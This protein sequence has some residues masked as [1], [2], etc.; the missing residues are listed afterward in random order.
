MTADRILVV[1]SKDAENEAV[2]L[3]GMASA[4]SSFYGG[5]RAAVPQI[6]TGNHWPAWEAY[7]RCGQF[8]HVEIGVSGFSSMCRGNVQRGPRLVRHGLFLC[9]FGGRIGHQQRRPAR[10]TPEG[11]AKSADTGVYAPT[12]PVD[13]LNFPDCVAM[14]FWTDR[15]HIG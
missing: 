7:L 12:A 3:E 9:V 5:G 2:G 15:P 8:G 1:E 11:S 10:W 14:R 6:G 4:S 13:R